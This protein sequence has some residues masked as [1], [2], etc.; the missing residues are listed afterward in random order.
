MIDYEKLK[1]CHE[2]CGRLGKYYFEV[3]LGLDCGLVELYEKGDPDLQFICNTESL[4]KLLEKLREL[5]EPEPKYKEAWYLGKESRLPKCTWVKNDVC[6][7]SCDKTDMEALGRHMYDSKAE[8][9]Q[10]QIDYWTNLQEPYAN[11]DTDYHAPTECEH[12][13]QTPESTSKIH[14]CLKCLEE[15]YRECEHEPSNYML[16]TNPPK[17]HCTKCGEFYI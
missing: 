6:Y 10:A 2:L 1:L 15:Y 13:S 14:T 7:Q 17:Y 9:I 4:D 16:T 11:E 12:V 8:L 5:T 3:D